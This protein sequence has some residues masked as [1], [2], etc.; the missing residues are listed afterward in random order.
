M[1]PKN[2][3]ELLDIL[4]GLGI[5]IVILGHSLQGANGG[6]IAGN[7][8]RFILH[9]QMELLFAISGFSAIYASKR[10]FANAMKRHLLRLGL[11]YVTWVVL[12]YTAEIAF[13]FKPWDASDVFSRFY[14]S[15][16]WFL[17]N[18]LFIYTAFEIYACRKSVSRLVAASVTIFI[19]SRIP[20]QG[21]LL[22][23]LAWFVLGISVHLL[24]RKTLPKK[25]LSNPLP[26]LISKP[27][28]WCGKN[29]LALYAIHWNIF[30]AFLSCRLFN[31]STLANGKLGF[32]LTALGLFMIYT[33]GSVIVI[34]LIKKLP[35]LPQILLGESFSKR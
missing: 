21:L 29:S 1:E 18:L 8:H 5:L 17:R 27:L 22:Y 31:F 30:F 15:G 20:E 23:Y 12:F 32:P 9:F 2:R 19:L 34:M 6:A 11:P 24:W 7:F 14:T 4:R 26:S 16:F 35:L 25:T 10:T 28:C 13:G 33:A 3:N